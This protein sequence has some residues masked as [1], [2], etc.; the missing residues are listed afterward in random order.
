[1]QR[2]R[3]RHQ[4]PDPS[5]AEGKAA[6]VGR[7][8]PRL[9]DVDALLDQ[10]PADSVR[11]DAIVEAA[12]AERDG[13]DPAQASLLQAPVR[14]RVDQRGVKERGAA[15]GITSAIHAKSVGIH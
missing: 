3:G 11:Q 8:P 7:C 5:L 13:G 2:G 4:A 1:M 9:E 14:E 6:V 10:P 15:S 12:A